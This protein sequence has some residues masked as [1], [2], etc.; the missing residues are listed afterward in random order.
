M[1][2]WSG[3]GAVAL[4]LV[5]GSFAS[6]ATVTTDTFGSGN[7][8]FDI[9]FVTISSNTNPTSGYGI[10]DY[11]Y[12]MGVFEI[13]NEQWNQFKASV[14]G[15][16][17]GDPSTAYDSD[18]FYTGASQPTNNVSW[19]EAAQFVNWLSTST[20]HQAAYNF[21]D[22]EL[23]LW[24]SSEA[25]DGSH[26][27]RHKDAYYFLPSEDE[28]VKAAYWN[29]TELQTYATE[30]DSIPVANVDS[31]YDRFSD[32]PWNVGSGSKELNGTYDM[33]GNV[34]EWVESP[35]IYSASTEYAASSR[36]AMRGGCYTMVNVG[37]LKSSVHS[38]RL[39]EY[40][41]SGVGFRIASSSAVPEPGSLIIWAC[42]SLG[43]FVLRRRRR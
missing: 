8:Q 4:C 41:S 6:A 26:L 40:E 21:V 18:A 13:T 24:D 42:G 20:G 10:V 5:L 39:P 17:T 28:W 34:L 27:Y 1:R 11:D 14:G 19:Y 29:G 25:A 30:D 12:R 15:T 32:G 31:S 23:T 37:G 38:N 2:F 22:G 35:F 43:A 9:Q 33:M 36:R 3:L 16:V 7:N